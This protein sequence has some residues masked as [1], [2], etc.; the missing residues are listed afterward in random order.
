MSN[1]GDAKR[2]LEEN[3]K[4]LAAEKESNKTKGALEAMVDD[5][6]KGKWDEIA[7]T[8]TAGD[9]ATVPGAVFT[10]E[11]LQTIMKMLHADEPK[12]KKPKSKAK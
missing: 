6:V 4:R 10:F 5:A 7:Q 9:N 8:V 3:K 12:I 11:Q 2:G 1:L